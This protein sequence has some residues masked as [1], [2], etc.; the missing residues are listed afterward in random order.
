MLYLSRKIIGT[1][2]FNTKYIDLVKY[3]LLD[4]SL[5]VGTQLLW[6]LDV[7]V[8]TWTLYFVNT[9]IFN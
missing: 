4:R 8:N 3:V 2:N 7:Y 1:S 6:L 9:I 5:F